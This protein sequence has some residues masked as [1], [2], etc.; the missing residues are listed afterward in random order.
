MGRF[1]TDRG[2]FD[3]E[4]GHGQGVA[5]PLDRFAV[6]QIPEATVTMGAHDNK[7][8]VVLAGGTDNFVGGP[9]RVI[10]QQFRFN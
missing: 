10:D 3:N 9:T 4:Q 8:D 7:I 2:L 1:D 5:D 6:N